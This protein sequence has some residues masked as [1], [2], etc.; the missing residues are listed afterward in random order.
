MTDHDNP[1]WLAQGGVVM[2]VPSA[3]LVS[4]HREAAGILKPAR[5]GHAAAFGRW[6]DDERCA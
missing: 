3:G 6:S 4:G 5:A 2:V 1:G